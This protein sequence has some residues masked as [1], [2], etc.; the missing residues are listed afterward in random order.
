[1]VINRQIMTSLPVA[2][3]K[4]LLELP[5][6]D[7]KHNEYLHEKSFKRVLLTLISYDNHLTISAW[8]KLE[9][10]EVDIALFVF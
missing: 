9:V 6:H 8:I 1:M 5:T 7:K 2:Y 3:I 10:S 4:S